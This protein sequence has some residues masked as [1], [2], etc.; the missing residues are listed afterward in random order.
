MAGSMYLVS[1]KLLYAVIV[2]MYNM[3]GCVSAGPWLM[4][5]EGEP[6]AD[7]Q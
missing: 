6:A 7:F 3:G 1:E 5:E 2:H 4:S